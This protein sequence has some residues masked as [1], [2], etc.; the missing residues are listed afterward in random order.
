MSR[1]GKESTDSSTY[2]DT[3]TGTGMVC[4]G[5]SNGEGM[6][7]ERQNGYKWGSMEYPVQHAE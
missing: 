1:L 3:E 7:E 6:D 2:V 4:A 5:K